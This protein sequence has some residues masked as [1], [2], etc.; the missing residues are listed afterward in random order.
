MSSSVENIT[1]NIASAESIK[2]RVIPGG[3]KRY[4]NIVNI[5]ESDLAGEIKNRKFVHDGIVMNIDRHEGSPSAS[6][7][8]AIKSEIGDEPLTGID[9]RIAYRFIKR[10]FDIVFSALVLILF[11]WVYAI[12][13]VAIKIEDPKGPVIFKQERIGKDGKP[14]M[15][16]K[17]RSMC[18]NAEEKLADLKELNEKTG[19]V[20]KMAN[21][22]RITRVGKVIRKLSLDELPQFVNV[23]RGDLTVVG[24]RPGL[25]AEVEAYNDYQRQRLL[26][27]QGITCYWQTRRNRDSITFDEWIDLD[28][29]YV[30]KCSVWSDLKLV[31]QTIGVV[32]TA[33]GN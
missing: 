11:W 2:P 13:A 12:I 5:S 8:A 4:D 3:A 32:L 14:F 30:R 9:D 7:M 17:F 31:I 23:L 21:D 22:P 16:Y 25:P 15:M 20:F 33:Q 18:V 1:E 27:K 28:L 19:P 24:P 29:L 10:A 6:R 26:V